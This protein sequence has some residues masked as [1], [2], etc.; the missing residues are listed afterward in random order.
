[1]LLKNRPSTRGSRAVSSDSI[2]ALLRAFVVCVVV[3]GAAGWGASTHAASPAAS[4]ARFQSCLDVPTT[5]SSGATALLGG[6]P[7]TMTGT[8]PLTGAPITLTANVPLTGPV[9]LMATVSLVASPNTATVAVTL[10]TTSVAEPASAAPSGITAQ[11]CMGCH[12]HDQVFQETADY[13]T[14]EG[15]KINPHVTVDPIEKSPSMASPHAS[16]Q[17]VVD[18]L[19]CHQPH[20]M[21]QPAAGEVKEPSI[22]YCYGCHHTTNFQ[23]CSKCH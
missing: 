20:S 17:N 16:G 21:P 4:P 5:G 8:V 1:M 15:Y 19:Q 12:S 6:T 11:M 3:V 7:I 13:T 23:A 18:C 2:R 10:T 9:T 14:F 22:D